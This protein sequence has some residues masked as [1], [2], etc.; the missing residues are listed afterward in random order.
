MFQVR[1]L[2]VKVWGPRSGKRGARKRG[3]RSGHRTEQIGDEVRGYEDE[4]EG[5]DN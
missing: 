5:P 2:H 3:A 4:D 1:R